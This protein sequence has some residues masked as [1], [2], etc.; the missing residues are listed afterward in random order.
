MTNYP[1]G[2]GSLMSES[3]NPDGTGTTVDGRV[4]FRVTRDGGTVVTT[5]PDEW[6]LTLEKVTPPWVQRC[7]YG[8]GPAYINSIDHLFVNTTS[9]IGE[10]E[11]NGSLAIGGYTQHIPQNPLGPYVLTLNYWDN[12]GPRAAIFAHFIFLSPD[13]NGDGIV[14]IADVATLAGIF[15]GSYEERA[16]Y[17]YDGVINMVDLGI[18]SGG[19]NTSCP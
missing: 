9:P 17:N 6:Y 2:S 13:L 10:Y 19:I 12:A 8:G 15:H 14:N 16:D 7:S 4:I 1:D 3:W 5:I 11:I 18:F